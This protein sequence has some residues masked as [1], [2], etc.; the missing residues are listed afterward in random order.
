MVQ[1]SNQHNKATITGIGEAL[2]AAREKKS[3]SID[4]VQRHTRINST[5]IKALEEGRCDEMLNPTYVKS[6]LKKYAEYLGLDSRH[7]IDQYSAL[8]PLCGLT[9]KTEGRPSIPLAAEN[10]R[11]LLSP[12]VISTVKFIAIGIAAIS[13][14]IFLG[15]KMKSFLGG[16]ALSSRA[17][18]ESKA[19]PVKGKS[20]KK[21]S[22]KAIAQ[23]ISIPRNVP[24]KLLLKVN[25]RVFV[26][27]KTDRNL[28]FERVL[29]KGTAEE[30]TAENVINIYVAKG[31]AIELVLNGKSL[32]SPGTG[33][34]KN[35]EITRSGVKVK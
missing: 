11:F 25:Q 30:F 31:E 34:M 35:I 5:V 9:A 16:K 27:L 22:E 12:A 28:L 18:M 15:V 2:R 21:T 6:F 19:A 3:L 8:C 26:K 4:Q 23:K 14:V 24:L 13:V 29:D 17:A 20:L 33:L 1:A 7:L 10:R 32:G